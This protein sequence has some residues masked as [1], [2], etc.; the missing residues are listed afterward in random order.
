PRAERVVVC[1]GQPRALL[2]QAACLAGAAQAPLFVSYG[3]AGEDAELRRWLAE[4]RT[5]EVFAA[6]SAAESCRDL[7]GI[8]VTALAD[9]DAVAAAYVQQQRKKGPIQT[10][11]VANPADVHN[12]LGGM[13][14]LA[15][16]I[17]LQRRAA[18]L[19]T[20][21]KGDNTAAR[22]RAAQKDPALAKADNLILAASLTAIP[23]ER[24][25]NPA[26]G[27]DEFIQMEPLTPAGDFEPFTF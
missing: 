5:R 17:A 26:P 6:G 14:T 27:K 2:L 8:Q 11:V 16:W 19:L 3:T 23:M 21:D 10:F 1:P 24:R 20:N 18:L 15:P 9:A 7:A 12:D 22:V 25:P 13:S 4:W